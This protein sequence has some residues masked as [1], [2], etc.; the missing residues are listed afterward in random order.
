MND[1]PVTIA[2][3]QPAAPAIARAAAKTP[4]IRAHAPSEI[5]CCDG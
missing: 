4:T 2:D 3:I 5:V 1:L